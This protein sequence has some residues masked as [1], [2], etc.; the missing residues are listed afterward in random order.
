MLVVVNVPGD[1]SA[2]TVHSAI[3]IDG[4]GD[5]TSENG[6][7]SGSGTELDPYIIEGLEIS[8]GSS[9]AIDIRDT[10]AH[11]VVQ[12][13]MLHSGSYYS[14]Y[15]MDSSNGTFRNNLIEDF[16]MGGSVQ[17][18]TDMVFLENTV[19]ESGYEGLSFW[20]CD[21]CELTNNSF[22]NCSFAALLLSRCTS[23]NIS[24]NNFDDGGIYIW[25]EQLDH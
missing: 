4:D 14:L 21:G 13:C 20:L 2:Y 25:G 22:D 11:Y 23:F 17:T 19:S 1:V 6:V 16:D 10:N 12:D 5:Y 3:A 8:P 18:C 7:T 15:L 24:S 9:T